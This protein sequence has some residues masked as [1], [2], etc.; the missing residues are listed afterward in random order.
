MRQIIDNLVGNALRI[1]PAGGVIVLALSAEGADAVLQV[2]D[3][4]PGLTTED[5]ALAFEPGVLYERY[6]GVRPVGSGVGL[7]LVG[8]LASRLG[9]SAQVGT[10]P[11]GGAAFTVRLPAASRDAGGVALRVP[12]APNSG[13]TARWRLRSPHRLAGKPSATG[14]ADDGSG[15]HHRRGSRGSGGPRIA[16]SAWTSSRS[17][18]RA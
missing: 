11:E 16:R 10:A 9:G 2:R 5:M 7:A 8:R 1:T 3:S 13:R 18:C 15:R 6:R 14:R 4:G 17:A 12:A